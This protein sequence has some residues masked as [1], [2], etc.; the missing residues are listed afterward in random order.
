MK[1]VIRMISG[2]VFRVQETPEEIW[3]YRESF[4]ERDYGFIFL[5]SYRFT[6]VPTPHQLRLKWCRI[7]SFEVES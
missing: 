1:T 2:E 5:T 7:E 6:P 4:Q 3:S